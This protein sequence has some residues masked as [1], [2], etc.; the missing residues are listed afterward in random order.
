ML[1]CRPVLDSF[2]SIAHF[3]VSGRG[4]N[5]HVVALSI[6]HPRGHSFSYQI[7]KTPGFYGTHGDGRLHV[8][9]MTGTRS[10]AGLVE[11]WFINAKPSVDTQGQLLDQASVGANSTI[12][13]FSTKPGSSTM[14]HARTYA[15]NHIAT[16]NNV[17]VLEDG[18]FYFTNDHGSHK[19]GLVSL[20]LLLY[21]LVIHSAFISNSSS[22]SSNTLSPPS[23]VPEP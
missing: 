4:L 19:A 8:V 21:H 6:D 12:E 7:L 16:P 15:N 20:L 23:S 10:P 22:S 1:R 3:N 13:V 14:T 9:G 5:D 11:L 18:S 2:I 17:A